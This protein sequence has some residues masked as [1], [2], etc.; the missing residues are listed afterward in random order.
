MEPNE[1]LRALALVRAA[2]K[3]DA[4]ASAAVLAT[5]ATDDLARQLAGLTAAFMTQMIGEAG[6][7]AAVDGLLGRVET[8]TR[9]RDG[10]E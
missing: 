10:Q 3:G 5:P 9:A 7:L 1:N 8:A 2:I 6:A 4:D